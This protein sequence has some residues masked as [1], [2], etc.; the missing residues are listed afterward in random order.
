M[1][2]RTV[3]YVPGHLRSQ[4]VRRQM[5]NRRAERCA[6]GNG[7]AILRGSRVTG[8]WTVVA[9]PITTKYFGRCSY[10]MGGLWP[11]PGGRAPV[12]SADL[13]M[14]KRGYPRSGKPW[15]DRF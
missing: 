6:G 14:S 7:A 11:A 4:P 3:V 10:L 1:S 15:T 5:E 12:G 13:A 8:G 2:R 9:K